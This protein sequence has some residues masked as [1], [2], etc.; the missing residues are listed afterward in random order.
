VGEN[1]KKVLKVFVLDVL[2]PHEPGLAEFA[3]ELAAVEGV[4]EV[5]I[6]LVELDAETATVNVAVAGQM[7]YNA[8]KDK[9]EALG[10]TVQSVDL[11]S[12]LNDPASALLGQRLR[13][14]L[15]E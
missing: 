6:S 7:E 5:V 11:V 2:K 4:A 9:I 10:G 12:I 13:L 14:A 1:G 15:R 3:E 8:V